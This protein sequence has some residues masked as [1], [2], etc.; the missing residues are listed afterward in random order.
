MKNL[1]FTGLI[2]ALTLGS[3]STVQQGKQAQNQHAEFLKLKGDWQIT[4]VEYSKSFKVK[5]FNEGA[6]AQCFVGS[7]WK[8]VPNNWTGSYTLNGENGC[9][10]VTQPIK[11]EVVNGNQ[12][13]F[14]KIYAGEKA[15]QNTA[16]Y[17]LGFSNQTDQS[18]TLT[19]D[20]PFGGEYVKVYYQFQKINNK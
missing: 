1:L 12:F 14:K 3:C 11:F 20:I 15:K 13:Q 5:P 7:I 18:F 9:P 10:S 17:V 4:R 19:Q 16:G 2:G 6:D 8:L